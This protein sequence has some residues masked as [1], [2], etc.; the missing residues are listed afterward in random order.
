MQLLIALLSFVIVS[1]AQAGEVLRLKSLGNVATHR[2]ATFTVADQDTG[3]YLVQWKS[4]VTEAE[5]KSVQDSGLKILSYI[6]D[7]AFLVQGDTNAAQAAAKL[8]FVRAV[9]PYERAMK[10]EP[11]LNR[12]GLFSLTDNVKVS[13]QLAP[14]AD[15]AAVQGFFRKSVEVGNNVLVGESSV[16]QLW[17]LAGRSDVLW[18]ERYLEVR[19]MDMS[20]EI[21]SAGDV[22][23][24][25]TRTGYESGT[26]VL[27]AEAAY[28]AGFNG[29]G[30][31]VAFADTGLDTG[32][33]NTVLADFRGQIKSGYAVGLGGSSWGD[34]MNH[35]THVAGSIAGN[36]ANSGGLIRGTAF[37]AQLVVEGMWSDIFNNILPPAVNKLFDMAYKEGARIHSNSWGAPNSNGRYD[38]MAVQADTWLFQNPDF[39][40]VFAAG[41]DGADMNK[42]GVADE[43][44]VSSPGS[45]KNV[46]TV[47][48]SK[49]LLLEGGLQRKISETKLVD[50]FS[51][52]PLAS[53]VLS[54]DPRGMAVFSSRG[55]TADGRLKPEVV[56]PG[57]NIVSA[58]S[59]HAKAKPEDSWGIYDDNYL[60]MGGTSMATPLT[61]GAMAIVRQYLVAKLG[62]N[63]SAAMMKA[64]VANTAEDLFP[65]QFGARASGQEQP[66]MRPNNHEGW[67][68][69]NL[70][71]LVSDRS[72]ALYDERTGLATGQEKAVAVDVRSGQALRVTMSYTDAPGAAAATRTLVNDLD[73][74]VVDSAGRTYYPNGKNA[75]DTINNTEEID[76]L[77][78]VPGT[79]QV[80]VSGSNVP[81]GKNGAQPYALVVSV[82]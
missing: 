78:A 55:P 56:A 62:N 36:G 67:G 74:R 70:N 32:D 59:K 20:G 76:L 65:G 17:N 13:V 43:G 60:F 66:T 6:P 38:N 21:V 1:A 52:E 46:L 27:N 29:A 11:E 50:K 12:N 2:L 37:G 75:K 68:R 7:D 10:L 48:A 24:A 57:T 73:V 30:Q 58:R 42:D 47:G 9:V 33:M 18:I 63:V 72:L 40:A 25:A 28:A 61:S 19:S 80:I 4:S 26:K 15:R 34:P 31:I 22:K 39:L 35:G 54:D 44:S 5:K 14:G 53:S 82:R 3:L 69:V 49:N 8:S 41:N 23:P 81:Q 71:T 45:A 79:Y 51:V 64:T 16:S 77:N